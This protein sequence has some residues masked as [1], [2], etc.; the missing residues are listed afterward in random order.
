MRMLVLAEDLN[1]K[2]TQQTIITTQQY[3][4]WHG[5]GYGM[6]STWVPL[7]QIE[8]ASIRDNSGGSSSNNYP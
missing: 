3:A 6:F 1:I 2:D 7:V 5:V 4:K 8:T